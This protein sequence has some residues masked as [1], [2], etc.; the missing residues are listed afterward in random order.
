MKPTDIQR[1]D[2]QAFFDRFNREHDGWSITLELIGTEIGA[3]IQ[4]REL[5]FEGIVNEGN[6]IMIMAGER[7][8][9]HITHRIAKPLHISFDENERADSVLVMIKAADGIT[10]LLKLRAPAFLEI[11]ESNHALAAK[12]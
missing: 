1:D 5:V 2:W 11:V 8:E 7:A 6:E 10:T 4:D 3:Q 12:S 9:S